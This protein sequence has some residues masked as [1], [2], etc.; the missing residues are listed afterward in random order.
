[1]TTDSPLSS[2]RSVDLPT[3]HD[4]DAHLTAIEAALSATG[5]AECEY[6]YSFLDTTEYPSVTVYAV[7]PEGCGEL[8]DAFCDVATVFDV[9]YH[10]ARRFED[11]CLELT[12]FAWTDADTD[13]DDADT[14]A[15][16]EG[17]A[18]TVRL[19]NGSGVRERHGDF[20]LSGP[21]HNG[22]R[23][24]FLN[25]AF[26]PGII[27]DAAQND[28]TVTFLRDGETVHEGRLA[29]YDLVDTEKLHYA[30]DV[31]E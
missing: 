16:A 26:K 12:F 3:D 13:T 5:F 2:A 1:M 23:R 19:D 31:A 24:L 6:T 11:S 17:V 10:S 27:E 9:E 30:I 28:A 22:E 7:P 18:S 14:D 8:A 15:D 4:L 25:S 29:G 20:Q 21:A